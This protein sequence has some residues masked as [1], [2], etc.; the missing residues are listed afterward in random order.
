M[1]SFK[2]RCFENTFF[3]S[4]VSAL[5][6]SP[7]EGF[8][9][10][11]DLASRVDSSSALADAG[12]INTAVT[13]DMTISICTKCFLISPAA[14]PTSIKC[15]TSTI[16]IFII[17]LKRTINTVF[18]LYKVSYL[19]RKKSCHSTSPTETHTI[20]VSKAEDFR[21]N[22]ALPVWWFSLSY[23]AFTSYYYE[24]LLVAAVRLAI[25]FARLLIVK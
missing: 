15:R 6:S 5:M 23:S 16:S 13:K 11:P 3:L 8:M 24:P 4:W 10:K 1:L 22:H 21:Q 12:T 2:G 18:S 19:S 7:D 14:F 20:T 9:R 25:D 17:I